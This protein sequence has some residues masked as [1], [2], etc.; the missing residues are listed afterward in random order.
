MPVWQTLLD[1]PRSHVFPWLGGRK[2]YG[3]G[4]TWRITGVLPA[5][6]GWY[7]FQLSG[8]SA[9]LLEPA[10]PPDW[11]ADAQITDKGY[12]VGN[13]FVPNRA[14]L[15]PDPDKLI[16]QTLPVFLVEPGLDRFVHVLVGFDMARRCIYVRQLFDQ[17][18]EEA[19]RRAFVD[20]RFD[21]HSIPG[22]PP[23]LDLA[24]RFA[25]RQRQLLEERRAEVERRR[26]EEE[27]REAARRNIGT[28]LG[29]RTLA[30]TDFHAAATAAMHV[31]GAELLDVRPGY[32][33]NEM[34]VQYR[35]ENRRL[36]CVCDKNTLAI[37]DSGI[38]L[39]DHRTGEKGDTYFT[40]ESL[41]GVVRQADR[42][43]R[44]VIYRHADGYEDDED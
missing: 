9:T 6:F 4:R 21:V 30:A 20:R 36:E 16:A 33:Q 5:E 29:R 22:V 26:L 13:R 19:V 42:E 23:A 39:A 12:L 25:S 7:N 27:R 3:H 34:I 43:G 32:R 8:R 40:L 17:G 35:F 41:P 44:L 28:G 10:E 37:L 15:D 11:V 18:Q 14:W 1:V 2:V 31:G 38:C 24:F